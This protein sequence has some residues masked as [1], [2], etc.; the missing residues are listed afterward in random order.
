MHTGV[1]R[2][3]KGEGTLTAAIVIP[4]ATVVGWDQRRVEWADVVW[5]AMRVH[6]GKVGREV[7]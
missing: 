1:A 2:L 4:L 7:W 6:V 3:G 5:L